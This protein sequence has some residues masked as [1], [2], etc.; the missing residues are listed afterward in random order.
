MSVGIMPPGGGIERVITQSDYNSLLRAAQEHSIL[1]KEI[2]GE[3]GYLQN[4]YEKRIGLCNEEAMA[5]CCL[6]F[7]D[8][9]SVKYSSPPSELVAGGAFTI[10]YNKIKLYSPSNVVIDEFH[11]NDIVEL[12][13]VE[14]RGSLVIHTVTGCKLNVFSTDVVLRSLYYNILM[15]HPE[16]RLKGDTLHTL[17]EVLARQA[18]SP[19]PNRNSAVVENQALITQAEP[20]RQPQPSQQLVFTV[21]GNQALQQQSS[22]LVDKRPRVAGARRAV[23]AACTYSGPSTLRDSNQHIHMLSD[24]LC[25]SGFTGEKV[26]LSEKNERAASTRQ[27]IVKSLQWLVQGASPGDSFFFGYSGATSQSGGILPCDYTASGEITTQEITSIVSELPPMTKL[28]IIFDVNG[29]VVY[30]VQA[31]LTKSHIILISGIGQSVVSSYCKSINYMPDPTALELRDL[32]EKA[33]CASPLI[34][35]SQSIQTTN[36]MLGAQHTEYVHLEGE[37]KEALLAYRKTDVG[38]WNPHQ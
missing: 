24:L 22:N 8:D 16:G 27:N 37:D 18:V 31:G 15:R 30:P 21:G 14:N 34:T 7:R 35:S 36:C 13:H 20:P 33:G 26:L 3:D 12:H 23:L 28:T 6:E 25:A 11:I 32:M 29:G 19:V 17:T 9:I 2:S 10:I 1:L 38:S 4:I 5:I